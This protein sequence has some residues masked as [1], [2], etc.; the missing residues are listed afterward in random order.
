[1][2]LV[3]D[4]FGEVTFRRDPVAGR[5]AVRV[6]HRHRVDAKVLFVGILKDQL[7]SVMRNMRIVFKLTLCSVNASGLS[8]ASYVLPSVLTTTPL[9]KSVISS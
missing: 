2:Q 8:D 5:H 7:G 9:E 1:M 6:R 4:G 3:S